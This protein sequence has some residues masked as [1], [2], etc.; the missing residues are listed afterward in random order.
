MKKHQAWN[1]SIIRF[2]SNSRPRQLSPA[3]VHGAAKNKLGAA[4]ACLH[5]RNEQVRHQVYLT[6]PELHV[7]N[8]SVCIETS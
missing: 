7:A 4:V 1:S 6:A 5:Q 8:I 2:Q 3:A